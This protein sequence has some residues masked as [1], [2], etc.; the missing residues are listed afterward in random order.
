MAGDILK[1][2]I[3]IA[4]GPRWGRIEGPGLGVDV[5]EDKVMEAHQTYLSEGVFPPYGDRFGTIC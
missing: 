5:D 1:E 3:P 4:E 2:P